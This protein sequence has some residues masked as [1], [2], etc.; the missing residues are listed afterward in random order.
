MKKVAIIMGSNSDLPI[1]QPALDMLRKLA[2]PFEAH[3]FS[4]HRT[5]FQ[6][7]N[8]RQMPRIMVSE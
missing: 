3:V 7:G 1:V 5:P 6:T 4:A 8:F 2:I